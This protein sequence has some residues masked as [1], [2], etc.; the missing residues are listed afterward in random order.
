MFIISA[1]KNQRRFAMVFYLVRHGQTD[2]NNERRIQGHSD[3]P[4]NETGYKQIHDL[5][6]KMAK[7]KLHFDRIISSP[8]SRARITAGIIAEKVGYDKEIIVDDLFIERYCGN[9]EG[10]LWY[11]GLNLDDPKYGMESYDQVSERVKKAIDGYNF[12][13]DERVMIASH[14]GTLT[15]LRTVLSDYKIGYSDP[16]APIIQGNVLCCIKEE[17]KETQFFNL[18]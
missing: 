15:A 6:D 14:G 18:F 8:L 10:V 3:V 1:T 2:W 11:P 12:S 17:G 4:M 5:A 13:K 9:L 7:E 16:E